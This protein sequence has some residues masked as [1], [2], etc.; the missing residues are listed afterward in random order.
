MQ[1]QTNSSSSLSNPY[2]PTSSSSNEKDPIVSN[3]ISQIKNDF[4]MIA[5]DLTPA[6]RKLY[7]SLIYSENYQAAKGLVAVGF[8]RAT[9]IYQDTAGEPLPGRSLPQDLARLEPPTSKSDQNAIAALSAHLAANPS[10]LAP[11]IE[12]RG[13]YLDLKV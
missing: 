11:D 12:R 2:L 3:Q 13:N 4:S 10:A 6:E 8:M 1:V 7:D 5:Q 9:G